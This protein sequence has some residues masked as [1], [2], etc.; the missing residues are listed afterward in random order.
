MNDKN[1][2]EEIRFCEF[3]Y[4][5]DNARQVF[6]AFTEQFCVNLLTVPDDKKTNSKEN[7]H[8]KNVKKL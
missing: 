2:L 5:R 6:L 3:L 4:T 1:I 7:S 8:M